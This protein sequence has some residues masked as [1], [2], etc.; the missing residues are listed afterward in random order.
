MK[1]AWYP[2]S[3]DYAVFSKYVEQ[4]LASLPTRFRK[5]LDNVVVTVEDYPN[6]FQQ[7]NAPGGL[8]LG[9]YQGIPQ[10]KRGSGYGVSGTLPDKITIFKN[11]ILAISQTEERV[12]AQ[13]RST[14]LHEIAHHFGMNE[15]AV[16]KAEASRKK[17]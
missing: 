4:A 5:K 7:M 13:I 17:K 2:T 15:S 8:L 14:V 1:D 6:E 11:S 16:R 12:I 10:T 9:L 3:M